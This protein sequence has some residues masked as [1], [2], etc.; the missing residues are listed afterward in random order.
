MQLVHTEEVTLQ[1]LIVQ[2]RVNG[3]LTMILLTGTYPQ[4]RV[5][6]L[7]AVCGVHRLPSATVVQEEPDLTLTWSQGM[8]E[9]IE[10]VSGTYEV[11]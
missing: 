7:C 4:F 10:R 9:P 1:P 8:L 11:I 2:V 6:T 5:T 3:N